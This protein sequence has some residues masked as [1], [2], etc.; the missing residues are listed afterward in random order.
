MYF[1]GMRLSGHGLRFIQRKHELYLSPA[2]A[3]ICRAPLYRFSRTSAVSHSLSDLWILRWDQNDASSSAVPVS[4]TLQSRWGC[5]ICNCGSP[6]AVKRRR[7]RF[8]SAPH[9][10]HRNNQKSSCKS[11]PSVNFPAEFK[12]T[13][14]GKHPTAEIRRE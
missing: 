8:R 12:H 13:N 14:R 1:K 7:R 4:L 2:P 11:S 10:R 9:C 5:Q 6:T 3:T